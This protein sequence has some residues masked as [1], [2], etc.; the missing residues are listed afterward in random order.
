MKTALSIGRVAMLL[1]AALLLLNSFEARACTSA[2]IT[3]K[4]TA[5]GKPLMWKHRDTSA[6]QNRL[7]YSDVGKYPYIG[8]V[9]S[10]DSCNNEVWA[11]T[12]ST[13]FCIMN[14]ASYNIRDKEDETV[15]KDF[16]GIMMR[17][18]LERC[19]SLG[20]F[21][22]FLDTLSR[23]MKVEA[24]FAVIDAQ[25]GAAYY[26]TNNFG[27][28]KADANNPM[29]APHGYLIRTNFSYSG[30][31]DQGM[32]Y[33]RHET[34]QYLFSR[35]RDRSTFTPEWIFTFASR[36]YY[37]SLLGTD[38]RD[39]DFN[40]PGATG[41]AID[42]DYISR[43]SSSASVVF[44]GVREGEPAEHTTMWTALGFP[45]CSVAV[46]A[47]VKGGNAL[48][49]MLLKGEESENA[50]LCEKVVALKRQVFPI[51]RGSGR[52]YFNWAALYNPDNSGIMQRL[53]PVEEELFKRSRAA[54]KQWGDGSWDTAAIQRFYL[55]VDRFVM[56]AYRELFDL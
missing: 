22:H 13:G 29:Q 47:W 6:E 46:P 53:A 43:S 10:N 8:L 51:T 28:L 1:V 12:N 37:H 32:G 41:Y 55:E 21:E 56:D 26:E 30:Y 33:I 7:V 27:Y 14:T 49:P 45:P 16:E 20:D 35:Q 17:M 5:D 15:E 52:R 50:P 42:Q 34:A 23:P 31:M 38:L 24:N 54:M 44:Q 9:N 25:G 19:S 3:G 39:Y 11:G 2:I 48:P 36:S 18:A 4:A 40:A